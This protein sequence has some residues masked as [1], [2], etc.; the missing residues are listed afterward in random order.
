VIEILRTESEARFSAKKD[1][2]PSEF[3]IIPIKT[4]NFDINSFDI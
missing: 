4:K 2:Y 1:L 3:L